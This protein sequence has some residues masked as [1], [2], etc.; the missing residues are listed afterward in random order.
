MH[1]GCGKF[2][3]L[4]LDLSREVTPSPTHASDTLLLPPTDATHD[5]SLQ[6]STLKALVPI[7]LLAA[8]RSYDDKYHSARNGRSMRDAWVVRDQGVVRSCSTLP[9]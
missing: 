2:K 9:V 5:D 3:A 1:Q 6:H 8:A 7:I 4:R